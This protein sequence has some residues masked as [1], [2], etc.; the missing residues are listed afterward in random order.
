M[1]DA[2]YWLGPHLTLSV[3]ILTNRFSLRLYTFVEH[4]SLKT[5][6]LLISKLSVLAGFM[7]QLESSE[8]K[9]R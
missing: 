2:S 8:R 4:A 5:T 7:C 9:E 1:A 6:E 3:I